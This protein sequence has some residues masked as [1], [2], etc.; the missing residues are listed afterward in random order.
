MEQKKVEIRLMGH[1]VIEIDG[2]IH[3]ELMTLSPKGVSLLELL[4]LAEG[5]TVQTD[6][7]RE[8]LWHHDTVGMDPEE[9]KNRKQREKI[10]LK[11]LVCRTRQYLNMLSPGL[12]ECIASER[13]AYSWK[14]FPDLSIDVEEI[15]T[16]CT[17]LT[18]AHRIFILLHI[19]RIR[20][21]RNKGTLFHF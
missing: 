11:T 4:I 17:T 20:F 14:S 5:Q 13:G 8:E 6:V 15:K 1:F 3:E 16:I 9:E 10:R 19:D 7:L 18:K 2:K 12:G 21:H